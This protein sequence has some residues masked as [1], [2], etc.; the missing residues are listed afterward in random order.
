MTTTNPYADRWDA[1]AEQHYRNDPMMRA[2]AQ[3]SRQYGTRTCQE[4][5]GPSFH[6]PGVGGFWCSQHHLWKREA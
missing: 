5:G 4:C 1:I 3:Q 6:R 2:E